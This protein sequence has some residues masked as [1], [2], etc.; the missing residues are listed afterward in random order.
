MNQN[1]RSFATDVEERLH[2]AYKAG[3]YNKKFGFENISSTA[4]LLDDELYE[5][6]K[7]PTTKSSSHSAFDR[8][9]HKDNTK[10]NRMQ[11]QARSFLLNNNV[12]ETSKMS[13]LSSTHS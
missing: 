9:L 2:R 8:I 11:D 13:L 12:A 4:D 3:N 5:E 10:L 1:I 7:D 6:S